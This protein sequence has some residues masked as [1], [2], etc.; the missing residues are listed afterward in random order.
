[1]INFDGVI[2]CA[3]KYYTKDE[4]NI[5]SSK[6]NINDFGENRVDALLK[7]RIEL[8]DR[9][10]NWH[11]IGYLQTNKIKSMIN[12]IDYLHSLSTIKQAELIQKYRNTPLK[13]FIQLN[14]S[15]EDSKS[16]ISVDK[17]EYFINEMKKYDK[18]EIVGLMTMG[19]ENDD[20]TTN[21]I[22]K[23][24]N[25]LKNKYQLLYT[26]MGMTNDYL[27]AI[28]NHSTHLRIGSYFKS[29]IGG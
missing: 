25:D 29:L 1:M 8:S 12:E 17:L 11:F 7:K 9:N 19:V 3:S 2:V 4:I 24:T 22:F 27:L 5:I 28:N 16:G 18:I 6:F 21:N 14:I 20:I 15:D 10:Y 23:I 13:C 26:S